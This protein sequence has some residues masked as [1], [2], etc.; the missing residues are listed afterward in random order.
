M[1]I[2]HI[3]IA[4]F[5][6][7]RTVRIDF[8]EEKT[9]FVGANNSGKTSAMVALRRFLVDPSNFSVT[10]F[11]L[12]HWKLLN[13]I[14]TG[15][16]SASADD[17]PIPSI[18]WDHI[19]PSLD[20]WLNTPIEEIHYV[21]KLLPTLDWQGGLLGVRLRL[22]PKSSEELQKEYLR[23]R[24][25]IREVLSSPV[26]VEV[27]VTPGNDTPPIIGPHSANQGEGKVEESTTT[28]KVALWPQSMTEFLDRR[29]RA[30]FT[31]NAYILDPAKLT[32][33][34]DGIAVPQVLLEGSEP[35]EGDPFQGLI[36]IDE[37]NAQRG[38]GQAS[39]KRPV[40]GASANAEKLEPRA[41]NRKLSNQLR[42]Y[43]DDHLDPFEQPGSKDLEALQAIEVAQSQ[44]DARLKDG[45]AAALK[46]LE[47]LN[48]PGVTDPK[49]TISTRIRPTDGL[50][51]DAAVQYEIPSYAATAAGILRL[52]EDSNG[53]G[54][55]NLVSMAFNLMSFRDAWMRVG[56]ASRSNNGDLGTIPPLHLV[57]IEEPEAH[58]HAQVQQVFIKEAYAI[59]RKHPKLGQS[60]SNHT[61][62]IVSTHS[63]H[64]AHECEFASLRYFRR[65]PASKESGG[66]PI[67]SVINLSE[68]FGP[69]T[70][71][72]RFVTRYLRATH[73]D[74][75]FADA[76][77]FIEGPAERILVPYLVQDR[78]EYDFIR[79]C[80]ITWLEV[81]GSH[82]HRLRNLI[83]H[84]GLTTLVITDIDAK[85]A[86][87]GIAVQ[88]T[89]GESQR[90][91]NE[92]LK[93][94]IPANESLD[95]LL[96]LPENAKV[97]SYDAG[98]CVR[99]AYQTPI[100]TTFKSSIEVEAL[101]NTFEDAL[102]FENISL[103]AQLEGTGLL[104]KFRKALDASP[105]VQ[106]LGSQMFD[107]LKTGI[108][109]E[110]ALALLD[111]ETPIVLQMPSYIHEGLAWLTEQLKRKQLDVVVESAS[112]TKAAS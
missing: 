74:L 73:S 41:G 71:T 3:E 60:K 57:L 28:F 92:T 86:T 78:K 45:F 26:S 4:N 15:W 100:R 102:V 53:L 42:A 30:L 23:A 67:T 89:R 29:L 97:R 36:C 38:F 1:H 13:D 109:A 84:L 99:V 27:K 49:L 32:P 25:D 33:P 65:I 70:A 11:T 76:A 39:G 62:L 6:K 55:Q 58:L 24:A 12:S 75:F 110:F 61:Q 103:F 9:I 35:I 96:D 63:N 37:I 59:L 69:E 79:R 20:I 64:I 91:R 104:G 34:T 80:Y 77:I 88:P 90:A 56:K 44:F 82:A 14:A 68:V 98:F 10:D 19:L 47:D 18:M 43:Y 81:G 50:N 106:V 40:R 7:L 111:L 112:L 107:A 105:D 51:H 17:Q 83:E 54:Y 16:E 8:S 21:Q 85:H 93:T 48:Y 94:W 95:E 46:E 66:I 5:R 108:K 2:Q 87:T 72:K 52:P 22:E 31:V 101:A